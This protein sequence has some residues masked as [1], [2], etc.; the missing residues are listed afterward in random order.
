MERLEQATTEPERAEARAA[1]TGEVA[2]YASTRSGRADVAADL[3]AAGD[4]G[5]WDT[6]A[7]LTTALRLG[8]SQAEAAREV[9]RVIRAERATR[10]LGTVQRG[11]VLYLKDGTE[12]HGG[13]EYMRRGTYVR[14]IRDNGDG[15]VEVSQLPFRQSDTNRVKRGPRSAD[16]RP[17]TDACGYTIPHG[18]LGRPAEDD[19]TL[20]YYAAR[21]HEY[22]RDYYTD[23]EWAQLQAEIEAEEDDWDHENDS[24]H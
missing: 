9:K 17:T 2:A 8:D 23:T 12:T 4:A 24:W 20:A 13:V 21:P 5:D 3:Q 7:W 16:Y 22:E 6:V 1:G 15:T 18:L 19:D 10:P 11:D 14:V